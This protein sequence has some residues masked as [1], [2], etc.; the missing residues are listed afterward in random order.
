MTGQPYRLGYLFPAAEKFG[1]VRCASQR[2]AAAQT[3]LAC[4]GG[5]VVASARSVAS[6][7]DQQR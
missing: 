3:N 2:S 7:D 6:A 1:T 5:A 4:Q